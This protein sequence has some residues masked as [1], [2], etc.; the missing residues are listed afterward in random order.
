MLRR[1]LPLKC[2]SASRPSFDGPPPTSGLCHRHQTSRCRLSTSRDRVLTVATVFQLLVAAFQPLAD[3]TPPSFN[4]SPPSST[5]PTTFRPLPVALH[6][7][8]AAVGPL[9]PVVSITL[10][11]FE[12]PCQDLVHST[13][14]PAEKV[15]RDPK[16][17][18][19]AVNDIVLIPEAIST[20]VL[21][22]MKQTAEIQTESAL[23]HLSPLLDIRDGL[24]APH[25]RLATP[26]A[27][28][29][30]LTGVV[31]PPP[32][33]SRLSSDHVLLGLYSTPSAPSDNTLG[34]LR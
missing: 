6:P 17:N 25:H 9:V 15:L 23:H 12:D 26:V 5:F 31:E 32:P 2:L 27:S 10:A 19:S 8:P 18:E 14:D 3:L 30:V 34:Y 29:R 24:P 13:H 7:L 4:L 22:K 11:R 20:M 33:V 1:A 28:F 16:I 21:R